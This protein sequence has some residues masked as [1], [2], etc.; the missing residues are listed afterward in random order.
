MTL[1]FYTDNNGCYGCKTCS[2]ACVTTKL[3][4][5][6]ETFMRRVTDILTDDTMTYAFLS[7]SCNHCENP[8]CL[9]NCPQGAYTKHENG[10]VEQDHDKCIGCKTC[11]T[12]C[13]YG[14]PVYDE[15]EGKVYKCDMCKDRLETGL[16]PACVEACPGANLECGEL[17][18]LRASHPDGVQE[19]AGITPSAS[20]TNPSLV[21]DLDPTLR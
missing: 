19:I 5:N 13:P 20:E 3:P 10:I 14:A 12:A 6:R 18:D 16:M 8:Q 9:A 21:I 17:D 1:G 11:T 15:A 7:L 4:G 2:V